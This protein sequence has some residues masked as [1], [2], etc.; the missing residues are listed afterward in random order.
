M[1]NSESPLQSEESFPGGDASEGFSPSEEG[2]RFFSSIMYDDYSP[3]CL[4]IQDGK[5]SSKFSKPPTL[6]ILNIH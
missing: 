4:D 6:D 1:T 5:E 3:K 2:S